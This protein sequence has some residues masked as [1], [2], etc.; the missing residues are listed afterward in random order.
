[1]SPKPARLAPW[2]VLAALLAPALAVHLAARPTPAQAQAWPVVILP[3][4]WVPPA[5][6]VLGL[7]LP[8]PPSAPPVDE[9]APGAVPDVAPDA[10]PGQDRE[11]E[12]RERAYPLD[13]LPREVGGSGA[14]RCP[15]VELVRYG[16]DLVRYRGGTRVHPAFRER[17]RR[18]EAI[19]RDTA[20]AVYGRAPTHMRLMGTYACRRIR[21]IDGLVSEHAFGNAID[22]AGFDF[23]A[24]R[25]PALAAN[26]P[27]PRLARA[28]GV[29]VLRHW[30]GRDGLAA[31]HARFLHTLARRLLAE[32]DLFRVLIGPADPDHRN[33]LH[34]DCAPYHYVRL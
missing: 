9:G 2:P 34:L 5:A 32:P 14:I 31:I 27:D 23:A 21:R 29:T 18:F 8:L 19:V 26:A 3:A 11:P 4:P 30:E 15:E 17:L 33:H 1:M 16:G 25:D 24:A 28:F 10:W 13:A 22:V 6:R 20:V 7:P 12:R